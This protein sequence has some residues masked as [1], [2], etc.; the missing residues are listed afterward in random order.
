[1]KDT[2][3]A[4]IMMKHSWNN[5]NF[6]SIATL[7]QL[8]QLSWNN[9]KNFAKLLRNTELLKFT[10]M[11]LYA[12]TLMDLLNHSWNLNDTIETLATLRKI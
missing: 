10:E 4:E 1:M 5:Y 9:Y 3:Y 8:L 11:S 2:L 12:K 6:K 7:L